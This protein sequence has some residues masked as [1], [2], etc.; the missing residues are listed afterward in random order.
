MFGQK[1]KN[2]LHL[3]AYAASTVWVYNTIFFFCYFSSNYQIIKC[4][5]VILPW[6]LIKFKK[7][8]IWYIVKQEL[9]P[10]MLATPWCNEIQARNME[11]FI[12]TRLA[13]QFLARAISDSYWLIPLREI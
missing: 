1:I 10:V 2:Y 5:N 12:L 7:C 4:Y 3:F 8:R 11:N 9:F 6:G 13:R